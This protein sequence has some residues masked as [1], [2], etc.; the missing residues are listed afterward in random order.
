MPP[1]APRRV[2]YLYILPAFAVFALFVL[3]PLLHAVWISFYQWDG[4]TVGTWVGLKNRMHAMPA[5]LAALQ[6]PLY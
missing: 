1:G 6:L 4:L 3:L 5:T 2:G